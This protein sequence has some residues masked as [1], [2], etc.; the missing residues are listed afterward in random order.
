M[1]SRYTRDLSRALPA[2]TGIEVGGTRFHGLKATSGAI[3]VPKSLGSVAQAF[4]YGILHW[5]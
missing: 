3:T 4:F 1:S 2:E 5:A